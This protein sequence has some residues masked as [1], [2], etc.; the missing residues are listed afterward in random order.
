MW[1]SHSYRN[2]TTANRAISCQL[3]TTPEDLSKQLP[4]CPHVIGEA[5]FH[6]RVKAEGLVGANEI[7]IGEVQGEERRIPTPACP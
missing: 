4:Q 3:D 7:V 6:C 5:G 1:L 2:G